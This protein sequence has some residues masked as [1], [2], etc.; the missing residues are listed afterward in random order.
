MTDF[1]KHQLVGLRYSGRGSELTSLTFLFT[2]GS[3]PPPGTYENPPAMN[4][5]IPVSRKLGKLVL[6][7]YDNALCSFSLMDDIGKFIAR[8]A[9]EQESTTFTVNLAAKERIVA[10]NVAV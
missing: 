7:S 9:Q 4:C 10:A 1:A 3:S 8:R 2:E 6:G 5:F